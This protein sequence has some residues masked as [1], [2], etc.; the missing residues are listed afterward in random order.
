M[1]RHWPAA[2]VERWIQALNRL[3]FDNHL[4]LVDLRG[5]DISGKELQ[6][7]FVMRDLSSP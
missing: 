5:M 3:A 6:N 4:M 2:L 7:R 1:Q